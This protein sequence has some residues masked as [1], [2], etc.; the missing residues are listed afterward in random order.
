MQ[1]S[2]FCIAA[3]IALV[4]ATACAGG[5]SR[6]SS[7]GRD[8][9]EGRLT[10]DHGVQAG[11]SAYLFVWAAESGSDEARS[12]LAVV[13]ADPAQPSYARVL[14]TVEISEI[15]RAHHTEHVMPEGRRILANAFRE[16][17]TY[18]IN[19][20]DPLSPVIESSFTNAG[21]YTFPH[22]FDRTPEGNVLAT[23]QNQGE[24]HA[25]PG[26]LVELDSLGRFVRG[27]DAADP[28]DPELRPYSVTLLA[29]GGRVVTTTADMMGEVTGRSFQVWSWPQLGLLHTVRLPPGPRGDENLDV[30]EARV[31]ADGE[32]VIVTTFRCGMY[33]VENL[34]SEHPGARLIYSF[35]WDSYEEG[36][37]C[38]LPVVVGRFWVQTVQSTRSLA[39]LDMTDP[40]R[41]VLVDELFLGPDAL[42]HW[43]T[44]EPGGQRIALTGDGSL[45]GRL[46]LLH[47]DPES[48]ALSLVEDFRSAGAT[49]PGVI[50]RRTATDAP[51]IPHGV[52][53][54]RPQ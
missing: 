20:E 25:E 34:L 3:L 31:L 22:S 53:F 8:D 47:L 38:G 5:D 33:L 40:E 15:S 50:V 19:L 13:G 42:P 6:S 46:L 37:E 29:E 12:Y 16:G 14:A 23:F 48:G 24:G 18:V 2:P 51:A 4:S 36:D 27:A 49:E 10:T 9:A 45:S 39:V 54:S 44:A 52:V 35:P 26:G 32:T 11:R 30:A 41:P 7:N 21:P 17:R 28:T 43:I 1:R